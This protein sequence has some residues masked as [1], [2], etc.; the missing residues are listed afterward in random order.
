MYDLRVIKADGT[1][2]PIHVEKQP[3]LDK[4]IELVGGWL[5]HHKTPTNKDILID[6]EGRMKG[7]P[8]NPAASSLA[9]FA[10]VGTAVLFLNGKFK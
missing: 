7:L 1:V 9:G 10:V 6:E 3:S 2:T 8:P 5:E 4:L